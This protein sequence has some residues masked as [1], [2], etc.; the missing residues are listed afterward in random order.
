MRIFQ[1]VLYTYLSVLARRISLTIKRFLVCG[2]FCYSRDLFVGFKGDVVGRWQSLLGI[3][4]PVLAFP[5]DSL[6]STTKVSVEIYNLLRE[7]FFQI[8]NTKAS[9]KITF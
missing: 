9:R 2:H 1:A 6:L 8:M 7:P 3:I 5:S 4:R